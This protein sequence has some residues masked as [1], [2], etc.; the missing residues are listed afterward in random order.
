VPHAEGRAARVAA[1]LL[2]VAQPRLQS[3]RCWWSCRT[4]RWH[5]DSI[6][7]ALPWH[8]SRRSPDSQLLVV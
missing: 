5:G 2:E 3:A 1:A 7:L 8:F 6:Q 4:M